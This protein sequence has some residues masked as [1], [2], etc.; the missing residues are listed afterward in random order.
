M[1]EM[2]LIALLLSLVPSL[3]AQFGASEIV[4]WRVSSLA[5]AMVS[6]LRISVALPRGL[7]PGASRILAFPI[8]GAQATAAAFLLAVALG[9]ASEL[10]AAIYLLALFTYL[11]IAAALFLRLAVSLLTSQRSAA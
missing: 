2:S 8:L 7:M 10:A 3:P 6:I 9:F 1:L 11:C 4:T 5:F